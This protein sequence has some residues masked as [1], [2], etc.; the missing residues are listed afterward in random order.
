V[1]RHEASV[2]KRKDSAIVEGSTNF[3][4]PQP[5]ARAIKPEYGHT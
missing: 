1:R 4:I 3:S 2:R 5:V